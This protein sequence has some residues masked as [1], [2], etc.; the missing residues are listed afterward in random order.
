MTTSNKPK[1]EHILHA[2]GIHEFL[3]ADSSIA[4]LEAY[5][6]A[7][8]NLYQLRTA[9]S[10]TMHV[11]LNSVGMEMPISYAMKRGKQLKDEYPD[12]GATHTAILAD[13]FIEIRLVDSFMRVMRFPNT[14]VRFFR[15]SRRDDAVTWLLKGD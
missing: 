7:L 11:L 9:D 10:P 15:T 4:S 1:C 12:I 3:L 14:R 2:N 5:Y 13:G 8:A 6:Q